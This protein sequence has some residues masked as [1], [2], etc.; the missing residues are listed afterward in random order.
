VN[1][2][3]YCRQHTSTLVILSTSRVYSIAPLADL[4]VRVANGAFAPDPARDLPPGL[5]AEGID[6][7]FPTTPPISLYGATK[8]SSELLALEYASA[9]DMPVW[10]N[11]CGVLAGAGQFGRADQ[12]IFS[13]WIHSWLRERPLRYIGFDGEGHQVRDCL[14]PADLVPLIDRQIAATDE[15]IPRVLNVAG[16]RSCARSLAQVS[17]WCREHIG[18][19][20]VERDPA[21]RRFDLPWVVLDTSRARKLW[22]WTPSRTCDAIFDEVLEHARQ[23]ADWLERS[24]D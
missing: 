23:H 21:P 2:L 6:E 20:R 22:N 7:T 1:L 24:S 11:R 9:Y 8:L 18:D 15:S 17:D 14:H 10:I 3:E 4:P 16:G 12:G 19:R 13:F 5:T